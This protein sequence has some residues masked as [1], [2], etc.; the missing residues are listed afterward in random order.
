MT[1]QATGIQYGFVYK[2]TRTETGESYIGQ[3]IHKPSYRWNNHKHNASVLN[4]KQRI[5][6]AIAEHGVD[7]FRFD[8]LLCCP[9]ERLYAYEIEFIKRFDASSRSGA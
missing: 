8:V 5:A 9:T 4:P 1:D 3:T 7:A 2:I 6:R